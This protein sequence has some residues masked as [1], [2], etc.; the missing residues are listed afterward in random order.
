MIQKNTQV[1]MQGI[2]EIKDYIGQQTINSLDDIA[3][4]NQ[5][6]YNIVPVPLYEHMRTKVKQ[7]KTRNLPNYFNLWKNLKPDINGYYGNWCGFHARLLVRLL[8]E[9]YNLKECNI[10]GYG[11]KRIVNHVAV[12]V[13]W[14]KKRYN[15]DPYFGLHY[16]DTTGTHLPFNKL[17]NLLKY[18]NFDKIQKQFAK[19]HLTKNV[20]TKSG[21]SA[22]THVWVKMNPLQFYNHIS[23]LFRGHGSDQQLRRKFGNAEH[24]QLMLL[25]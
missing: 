18:K 13:V 8:K 23:N 20:M 19:E 5:F 11:L 16:A 22:A 17:K 12:M 10:W 9:V 1:I 3:A 15:F 2:Q 25:V 24:M 4:I 6:V 7:I 21:E 14:N